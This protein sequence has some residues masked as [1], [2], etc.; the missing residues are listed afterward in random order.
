MKKDKFIC[1]SVFLSFSI[2]GVLQAQYVTIPDAAFRAYLQAQYPACMSGGQLDTTCAAVLNAQH[3]SPYNQAISDLTGMQYFKFLVE[4][5]C[6]GNALAS[7]PQLPSTLQFFYC[8]HNQLTSLPVL[9]SSLSRLACGNNHLTH[10][11]ALPSALDSF[12]CT[13]NQLISLPSLPNSLKYLLCDTNSIACLPALPD[14]LQELA[15]K[16]NYITCL[17]NLPAPATFISDIGTAVCNS[18]NNSNSCKTTTVTAIQEG[19]EK[20]EVTVYPNPSNGLVTVASSLHG[21]GTIKVSATDGQLLYRI[22][23]AELFGTTSIDLSTAP[24][25]IYLLQFVTTDQVRTSK[26]ILN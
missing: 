3:L 1:L 25:G 17:P 23:K 20:D 19:Q 7:L 10:L 13:N 21:A 16:R 18:S 24:K 14:G 8:D 6:H 4:L 2:V 26:L 15:A 11:L 9:L 5:D 22:E 12:S